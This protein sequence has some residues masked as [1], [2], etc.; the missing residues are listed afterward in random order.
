MAP[1]EDRFDIDSLGRITVVKVLDYEDRQESRIVFKALQDTLPDDIS[2][3]GLVLFKFNN[4]NDIPVVDTVVHVAYN[5]P[6][7]RILSDAILADYSP[8]NTIY[9]SD[10]PPTDRDLIMYHG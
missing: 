8:M 2:L 3:P 1:D 7:H 6:S 4:L 9:G 5:A 10:E